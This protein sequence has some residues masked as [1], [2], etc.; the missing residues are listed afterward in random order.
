MSNNDNLF[1]IFANTYVIIAGCPR[2]GPAALDF[3]REHD[4]PTDRADNRHPISGTW[5]DETYFR[6]LHAAGYK[7]EYFS[8]G[9]CRIDAVDNDGSSFPRVAN[10]NEQTR[11]GATYG[12]RAQVAPSTIRQGDIAVLLAIAADSPAAQREREE[13]EAKLRELRAKRDALNAEIGLLVL[14]VLGE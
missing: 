6:Q 14:P 2:S 3:R 5:Y 7:F 1:K 9:T 11:H 12:W 4:L 13:R 8:D 10:G